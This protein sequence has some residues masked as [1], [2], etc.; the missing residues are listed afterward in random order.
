M[1]DESIRRILENADARNRAFREGEAAFQI[2]AHGSP[3]DYYAPSE[4]R[5]KLFQDNHG[6]PER[7]QEAVGTLEGGTGVLDFCKI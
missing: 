6:A 2:R 7:E 3:E 1:Y 5:P 4:A